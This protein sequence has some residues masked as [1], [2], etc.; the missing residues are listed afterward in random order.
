MLF[1]SSCVT[2]SNLL[3]SAVNKP[4]RAPL[5]AE[6]VWAVTLPE[7]FGTWDSKLT[8]LAHSHYV[9]PEYFLIIMHFTITNNI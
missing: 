9:S 3:P 6:L 4:G 5:S 8:A 2:I 7:N 1:K